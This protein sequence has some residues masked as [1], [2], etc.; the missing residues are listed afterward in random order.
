[1]RQSEIEALVRRGLL[2]PDKQTDRT[3]VPKAMYSF[4]DQALGGERDAQHGVGDA[5]QEAGDAQPTPLGRR[6]I[7][8]ARR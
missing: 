1:L 4:L 2:S 3:A 5:Q 8:P 6:S 7:G